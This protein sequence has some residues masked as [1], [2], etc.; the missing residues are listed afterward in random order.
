MEHT[1]RETASRTI[2]ITKLL[3][4]PIETVWAVWTSAAHLANWWGPTGFA[5]TIHALHLVPGGEWS[6]TLHGPD[7]KNYANKSRFVEIIFQRK[8]VFQHFNPDYEATISFE[9]KET[10]TLLEW[11]MLFETPELLET[12]V[13]VFRADE[14]L[15]QNVEKLENYIKL[16]TP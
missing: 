1:T 7:G 15:R 9:S 4:A 6:L 10:G 2:H 13:K 3:E 8:I 11:T 16:K 14:G 5:N 12:V